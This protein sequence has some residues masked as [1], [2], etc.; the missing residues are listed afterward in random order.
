MDI[1]ISSDNQNY[2]KRLIE[3]GN[4]NKVD[5]ILNEAVHLHELFKN[6]RLKTYKIKF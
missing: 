4:Y 3:T 6:S 5:E 2:I 1:T